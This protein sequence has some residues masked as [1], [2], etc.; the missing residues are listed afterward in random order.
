MHYLTE[1]TPISVISF[2]FSFPLRSLRN[3]P[4]YLLRVLKYFLSFELHPFFRFFHIILFSLIFSKTS[5]FVNLFT[6][7]IFSSTIFK[8]LTFFISQIEKCQGP[9]R[10]SQYFTLFLSYI[11][12]H[13]KLRIYTIYCLSKRYKNI[14]F[15]L[16]WPQFS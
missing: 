11:Y 12:H 13:M 6:H 16:I 3:T 15:G 10:R 2:A 1:N 8:K 9:G 14:S 4:S 5:S 7:L